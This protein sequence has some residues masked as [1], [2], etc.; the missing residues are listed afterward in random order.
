MYFIGVITH[1]L[2]MHFPILIIWMSLLTFVGAS[3]GFLL[4]DE[5]HV[6]KQTSPKWDATFCGV[7]SGAI[8]F[9]LC[10]IKR[11]PGLFGLNYKRNKYFFQFCKCDISFPANQEPALQAKKRVQPEFAKT[12]PMKSE[13]NLLT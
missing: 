1:L 6:S 5:I 7:T 11:T 2:G 12:S 10:P 3:E 9:A 8:L 13:T 4:S